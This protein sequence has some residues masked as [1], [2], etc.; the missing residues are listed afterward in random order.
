MLIESG[1]PS[2]EEIG[3]PESEIADTRP[4]RE[5]AQVTETV[6]AGD[7]AEKR[8]EQLL[9]AETEGK[10]DYYRLHL[11]PYNEGTV[12]KL[13]SAEALLRQRKNELRDSVSQAEISAVEQLQRIAAGETGDDVKRTRDSLVSSKIRN[14]SPERGDMTHLEGFLKSA[15]GPEAPLQDDYPSSGKRALREIDGYR[16]AAMEDGQLDRAFDGFR[17]KS[18][19]REI[20]RSSPNSETI[21]F[22]DIESRDPTPSKDPIERLGMNKSVGELGAEIGELQYMIDS[23]AKLKGEKARSAQEV[24]PGIKDAIAER[25]QAVAIAGRREF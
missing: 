1:G 11:D 9:I 18:R 6:E 24:I 22:V 14:Y 2:P 10:V 25:E 4:G 12:Q 8:R 15:V 21:S 3:I 23:A 17:I 13:A 16:N 7:A 20:R 19:I 5:T